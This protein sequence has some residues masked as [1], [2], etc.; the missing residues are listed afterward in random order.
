MEKEDTKF[1]ALEQLHERRK[2]VVRLHRKGY[3]VIDR[4]KKAYEQRPEAVQAWLDEHY[5]EIEVRAKA[6]CA[7]THWSDETALVNTDVCGRCYAPAGKT[8]AVHV[9]GGTQQK[10]SM[11]ATVTN[12]GKTRWIIIDD[13][14]NSGK[15][16]LSSW[17]HCSRTPAKRCS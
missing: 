14:F 10:L 6:E 11:I 4:F 17:Q 12:Q 1:Q 8:P 15:L 13:A 7:E 16:T 3:G 2:Q 9:V 5:P